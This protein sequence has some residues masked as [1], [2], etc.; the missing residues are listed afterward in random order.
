MLLSDFLKTILDMYR[1]NRKYYHDIE[2][3]NSNF[4][5]FGQCYSYECSKE[6][7]H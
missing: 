6:M 5:S 1:Y 2:F 3:K 4:Y 7:Y